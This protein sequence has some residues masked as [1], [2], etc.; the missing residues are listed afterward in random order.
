MPKATS[1]EGVGD[2]DFVWGKQNYETGQ[3]YGFE[4][5]IDGRTRKNKIDGEDFMRT[6]PE[7]FENGV[8]TKGDKLHPN[9]IYI[10]D[11]KNKISLEPTWKGKSRNWMLTAFKQNKADSKRLSSFV[12]GSDITPKEGSYSTSRLTSANNI[13]SPSQSNLNPTTPRTQQNSQIPPLESEEDWL[14]RLRRQ[15]QRRGLF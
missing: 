6:L 10:E 2:I 15:R 3:G 11:P 4:H 8:V 12:P 14:K 5:I 9:R 13:I 1:K 7:T